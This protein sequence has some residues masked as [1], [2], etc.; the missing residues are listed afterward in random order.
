M[1]MVSLNVGLI[2]IPVILHLDKLC[3]LEHWE[4]TMLLVQHS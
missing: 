2:Y 3:I 1:F 4:M